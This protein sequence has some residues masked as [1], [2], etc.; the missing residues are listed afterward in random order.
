MV[1]AQIAR[2]YEYEASHRIH[3]DRKIYIFDFS[4]WKRRNSKSTGL[5]DLILIRKFWTNFCAQRM[6]NISYIVVECQLFT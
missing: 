5:T 6:A 2:M 4:L 1:W 3:N